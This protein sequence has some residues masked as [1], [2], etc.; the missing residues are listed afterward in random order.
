MLIAARELPNPWVTLSVCL[1][2]FI[3]GVFVMMNIGGAPKR[4]H[5]KMNRT[6]RGFLD[7]YDFQ[8]AIGAGLTLVG[9]WGMTGSL[10]RL[11]G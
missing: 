2:L 6:P 8:R 7:S 3:V 5:E 11:A 9:V 4:I 10:V 1:F